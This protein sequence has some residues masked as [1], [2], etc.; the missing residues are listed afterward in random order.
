MFYDAKCSSH[1]ACT[2]NFAHEDLDALFCCPSKDGDLLACC[3]FE[4]ESQKQTWGMVVGIFDQLIGF[5]AQTK[6]VP[7]VLGFLGILPVCFYIYRLA[8]LE[9]YEDFRNDLITTK[10]SMFLACLTMPLCIIVLP[11]ILM[12]ILLGFWAPLLAI[13][14][15]SFLQAYI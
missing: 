9:D 2:I 14:I 7:P 15:Y 10:K 3:V 5:A 6:V 1:K 4:T 8:T 12:T 13:C 11:W